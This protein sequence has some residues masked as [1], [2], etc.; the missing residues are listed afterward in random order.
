MCYRLYY[1]NDGC[2]PAVS[3]FFSYNED[4]Q[5]LQVTLDNEITIISSHVIYVYVSLYVASPCILLFACIN[6]SLL[7]YNG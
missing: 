1:I 4:C 7:K 3:P 6:S 2:I 5:F